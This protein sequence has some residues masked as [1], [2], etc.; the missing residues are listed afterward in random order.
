MIVDKKKFKHDRPYQRASVV[1][2]LP[3][4]A[5]L[6]NVKCFIIIKGESF[7]SYRKTCQVSCEC[8][9]S[10]TILDPTNNVLLGDLGGTATNMTCNKNNV[11][12]MSVPRSV[13][14]AINTM[15]VHKD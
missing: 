1:S 3:C 8:F 6:I 14:I 4:H 13:G 9:F 10:L 15:R 12:V 7:M 2:L 11:Q 5:L